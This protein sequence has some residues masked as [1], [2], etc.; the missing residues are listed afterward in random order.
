TED[1]LYEKYQS[2]R[3]AGERTPQIFVVRPAAITGPRGRYMRIRFGLQS[4]LSGNLKGG[5]VNKLVTT[6][7]AFVPATKGWARQF[8][9]ED[10]VTDIVTL[11]TF[12][13]FSLPYQV[14]NI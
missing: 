4:A 5:L 8:I 1:R 11:F 7:T 6:L 9:H 3:E 10:D 12:E 14:F 2:A 13:P